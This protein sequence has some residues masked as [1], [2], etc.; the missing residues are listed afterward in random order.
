MAFL[1]KLRRSLLLG[2]LL[3]F[4]LNGV[5]LPSNFT[6]AA[7]PTPV[8]PVSGFTLTQG[9]RKTVL[10]NG[11]T[12]LTKEVHTAPVVSVQIWY[13]VGSRNEGPGVNGISHQ[14]EHLMFKGTHDRP[15]QFGRLFS[16]LGSQ[17]NAFTSYDE[18]AYFNTVERDKLEALL[19]LEA[20]RMQGA[21]IEPEQLASEKRVVISELQ[22][23]E[24]SPGY[25]LNRA[26][27]RSVFPNQPY[28]LPVGGT[29]ADVEKFTLEQVRNY[30]RT[31]YSPKDATLVITGDFAT[32]PVLK[33]INRIFGKLQNQ[34]SQD[35]KPS[36]VAGASS[37]TI[38]PDLK[39]PSG[40]KKAPIVLK[41][42]G[43]A[44]LLQV[45]YPLPDINHPDV[46]AIDV[47]DAILT[48][49]RS[50][51]LYQALVETGLASSVGGSAS[52]LRAG[53]WY[54]VS[55]TAA[56][57]KP[58]STVAQV[59]QQSLGKLQ[60]EQVTTE[61]L[62]RAKT[63]LQAS[64]I[65]SNQDIA[66]QATQLAFNQTVAGD[67]RYAERYLDAVAKI[68]PADVL[69]VAKTYLNPRS[70]TIGFF[71]P[72]QATGKAGS[73]SAGTGRTAENFSPGKPVNPAELAKYLPPATT[74]TVSTK[75]TLPEEFKLNNGLRVLLLAD[76]SVP[77]VNLS[78]Q[79]DAGTEF[80]TNQ[81]A[82]L[83]SLT[84]GNLINGTQTQN[85]LTLAKSLEDRGI[86]LGFSA[87]REGVSVAAHSLSA[88]LPRL[89]KTLADVMQNATF[90]TDQLELSRQRA[91]ISLK[92][93][94]D[95]PRALGRR[96][97]QQAI[98][99]VNHPFHSFPTEQSLKSIT[100]DDL[101]RFYQEH[102]RPDT[103]TLALV[104]DFDPVQVKT[105]LNQAFGKWEAKGKPPVI[106]VPSVSLPQT[107]TR[108][109]QVIPGKSEA[110]TY[111]GYN[112]ISRKDP[113]FYSALVLNQILGGDTLSS[114]LGTE[115]RDRQGLTYGIYS[116]FAAGVYPG[117][118]LIQMQTSPGDAQKA[119]SSTL[120][121]LR[122]LREQG[123]TE[124]ELNNAKRSITSNYPVDLSSPSDVASLILNNAI[125]GLSPAEIREFPKHIEAVSMAQVQQAIQELIHPE[126]LVIVTTGP[127]DTTPRSSS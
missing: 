108:S 37:S 18:T 5:L 50:S 38:S 12:V 33:S 29:K 31:Y 82:G 85:A 66:S 78:G 42:P 105:L 75:Q 49:G 34:V 103:T 30:Y 39:A 72:T 110:V 15:V 115:V 17:F 99:P 116:A 28:G 90:P 127:E 56:A 6:N 11:L 69:R 3:S 76:H 64:F 45:V 113:R 109:N 73:S 48:G 91:L 120:A 114:R 58:L 20:D 60:Q 106:K 40:V 93:V 121:L 53:G 101:V 16:A 83:A 46:P 111:I 112:G 88:N 98:Y 7:T 27:M 54:D 122:Q 24:N 118:F 19:I 61:E 55:A 51:R 117:P 47:M 2:L 89:V 36:A 80:D 107:T 92:L 8:T 102:Y 81:K 57:G 23:Y 65:L 100:R 119:I 123:V 26:V 4:F 63:Q 41:Q 96:L 74:S 68:T 126:K 124:A 43:S 13:R 71:E 14:L 84:A 35:K 32:E 94:L 77:T 104:G 21:L 44:A 79:I 52:E 59:I 22:G 87:G 86:G 9:V 67:Y 62:N 25:R 125:Y 95:D 97:F 1:F 70:Q 10:D